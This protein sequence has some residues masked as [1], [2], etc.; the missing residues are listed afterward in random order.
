[1]HDAV[2]MGLQRCVPPLG[3]SKLGMM[4]LVQLMQPGRAL[5]RLA[6]LTPYVIRGLL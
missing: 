3:F 6:L 4:V 5:L 2:A 1:M